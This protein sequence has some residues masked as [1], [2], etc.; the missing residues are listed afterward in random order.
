LFIIFGLRGR[1]I[2][3]SSG[4]FYCPSCNETRPYKRNRAANYF[5]LFFIPL[6]PVQ[7]LGEHIACQV[8]KQRFTPDVLN[9]KPPSPLERLLVLA[10]ADLESGT[11]IQMTHRK[12]LNSGIDEQT[13]QKVVDIAV[14]DWQKICRKCGL[15]YRES[16]TLCS[17]CGNRLNE[18]I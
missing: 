7:N 10:R 17:S 6:F 13:A 2:K 18:P 14:G 8:C 12:L 4:K 5:T 9:Y 1:E 3:L 16:I 15:S 11:P